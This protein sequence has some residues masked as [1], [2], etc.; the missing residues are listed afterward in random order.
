MFICDEVRAGTSPAA[1]AAGLAA[2]ACGSSLTRVSHAAWDSG[3]TAVRLVPE[4]AGLRLVRVLCRGPGHPGLVQVLILRWEAAAG[5]AQPFA[6]LDAD[7]TL[8]PDGDRAVLLGIAGVYR[9]PP[10]TRP[11]QPDVRTAAAVTARALL[12]RIADAITGPAVPAVQV[13]DPAAPPG[14]L[15]CASPAPR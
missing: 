8:I 7:I 10:G 2:L 11:G 6:A 15:S 13:G 5:S 4:L 14:R 1:A 12:S 9:T 3:I